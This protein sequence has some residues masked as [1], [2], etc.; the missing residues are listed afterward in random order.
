MTVYLKPTD[1]KHYIN[2]KGKTIELTRCSDG[3]WRDAEG[4]IFAYAENNPGD[5]T[6][7]RCGVG[8]LSLS[9][10]NILTPAC[11]IHDYKASSPA[12]QMYHT[13]GEAAR[14]LRRD[15]RQVAK[16]SI[17]RILAQPFKNIVDIFGSRYWDN[18]KTR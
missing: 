2:F 3:L 12:Y 7:V 5:D 11:S 8:F 10:D 18:K 6:I 15:I 16:H 13:A 4:G 9:T 17:Y 1:T 14:D